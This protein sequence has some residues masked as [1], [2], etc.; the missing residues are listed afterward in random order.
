M[1]HRTV[2]RTPPALRDDIADL[3]SRRPVPGPA[4]DRIGAKVR[5]EGLGGRDVFLYVV[6]GH[7][8]VEGAPVGTEQ[9]V[10]LNADGDTLEIVAMGNVVPLFRHADPID[11]PVAAHGP[12]VMNTPAEIE[13]AMRDYQAGK[14]NGPLG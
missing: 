1:T 12:F 11:E 2:K 13:Q 3:R 14:F 4:L 5:F 10:E 6:R 9:L 7:I 8:R